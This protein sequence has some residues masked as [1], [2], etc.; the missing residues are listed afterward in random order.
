MYFESFLLLIAV[1]QFPSFFFSFDFS[2]LLEALV[3]SLLLLVFCLD[4]KVKYKNLMGIVCMCGL[5]IGKL[6]LE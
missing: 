5:G 3:R 4:A 2:F 1:P 6:H